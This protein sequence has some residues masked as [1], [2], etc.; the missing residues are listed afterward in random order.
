[1]PG[2]ALPRVARLTVA[3]ELARESVPVGSLAW[4]EADRVAAFQAEPGFVARGL[5]LSPF[6]LPVQEGLVMG[7]AAP[8]EGLHGV[9]ADSLPDGWG[10]LLVD[11]T[12]AAQGGEPA[13]LSP[14]DRLAFVGQR[15]MGALT[16][17]PERLLG[18]GGRP[19]EADLDWFAQ[20]ARALEAGREAEGVEALLRANGGS[21]GARP[22][23]LVLWDSATGAL[24]PDGGQVARP[25]EEA[26][27]VKLPSRVDGRD[28]G[29]VEHAYALMAQAAGVD[30]PETML[31]PG[32]AGAAFFAAR[33]FDRVGQER[34][35]VHTLAG[36]LPADFRVPSLDYVDLLK[37][38]RLLT[39]DAAQVEQAY[40]RMVFNVLA[41]NRDDH[42]KNHAF[43][44]DRAGT[45]R[46]SPAYDLT[47]S[48]GPGGQHN[49]AVAGEGRAPGPAQFA[50]V[51]ARAS[52]GRAAALRIEAAVRNAVG[53]WPE[54]ARSAGLGRARMVAV[55]RVLAG[56]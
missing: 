33:R 56:G 41:R 4:S 2:R 9:F 36:L 39:R 29:R 5:S 49:L 55:R 15:G 12:I 30:M 20:Q 16:Y 8:F 37:V 38:A 25:D 52:I 27:L 14:L 13:A 22:K 7:P 54:W 6:R 53:R 51:A 24:R 44:M 23:V 28:A 35:H 21:A 10:K 18:Q 47:P 45:W 1:M 46:L 40:R 26:L 3:L 50:E 31:L 43:T 32:R 19:G 11:R 48:D 42:A 34:T 17:A